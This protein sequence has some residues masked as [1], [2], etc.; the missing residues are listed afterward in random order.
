MRLLDG[1]YYSV[2]YSLKRSS[3]Y[4]DNGIAFLKHL[5]TGNHAATCMDVYSNL[6]W[7]GIPH[8]GLRECLKPWGVSYTFDSKTIVIH[9]GWR[10]EP[11][12]IPFK[13]TTRRHLHTYL[14]ES[15]FDNDYF[16]RGLPCVKERSYLPGVGV[17]ALRVDDETR[18][19]VD[20]LYLCEYS[21]SK[22]AEVWEQYGAILHDH[23]KLINP[24]HQEQ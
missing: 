15:I 22:F 4:D 13:E 3:S 18:I 11:I 5:Q 19:Y 20:G 12:R 8:R 16:P 10:K 1:L 14:I 24:I 23:Y 17:S 7:L 21:S 2:G 9:R 6:H